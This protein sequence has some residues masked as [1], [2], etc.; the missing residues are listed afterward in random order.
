MAQD[1]TLL[2]ANYS[3]VPAVELPKTGGGTASF[4]DIADTTA[5]A[6][7]VAQGKYFYDSAGVRTEGTASGGGGG[8]WHKDDGKTHLHIVIPNNLLKTVNLSF[9][10][11]VSGGNVIDW[12]DNTATTTPTGTSRQLVS[13]TYSDTGEHEITITNSSGYFSFGNTLTIGGYIFEETGGN[14]SADKFYSYAMMLSKVEIGKGWD[15]S[16]NRQFQN[17][18]ALE[19]VYVNTKLEST[20][21]GTSLFENCTTLRKISGIDK[22]D[23]TITTCNNSIFSGCRSFSDIYIPPNV[24][25]LPNNYCAQGAN[26]YSGGTRSINL[27]GIVTIGN[28]AFTNMVGLSY[29]EIPSTVTSIGK[30]AFNNCNG[31]QEIHLKPST[32]PTL[33]NANAFSITATTAHSCVMYVPAGKLSAYQSASNWSTFSSY[34]QEES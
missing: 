10:Q 12:G 5:V 31:L 7:D 15:S 13:H 32:P 18:R 28:S 20:S 21:F 19:E 4:T 23:T 2:G 16:K 26:A 30:S 8:T 27:T 9:T 29:L 3:A 33:S 17:C 34:M 25:A 24:T 6:A 14:N 11:T 22:W 1:I